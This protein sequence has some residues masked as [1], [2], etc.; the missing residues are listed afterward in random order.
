LSLF[1]GLRRLLR[2]L[3][4]AEDGIGGRGVLAERPAVSEPVLS[5]FKGLRRLLRALESAE[6]GT[7]AA[8]A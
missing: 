6:D 8:P 2:A 5:L 7:G 4:S 3:A 1:K